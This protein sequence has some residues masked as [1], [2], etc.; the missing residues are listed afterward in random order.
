M[1]KGTRT[2]WA[3][4][5]VTA[6]ALLLLAPSAMAREFKVKI[7]NLTDGQPLTPPVIATHRGRHQVFDVG[8]PASVGVREIAENGNSAPLLAQLEAD[9]FNRVKDF[10]ESSAGPLAP[11][12]TPGSA[13]FDDRVKLR[14]QGRAHDRLSWVSMLICTNDGFTGVDGL[15]LPKHVGD[16]TRAR[17]NG[18][19][20]HTELNTEDY[21]DIVPPCQGLIGDT[22]GEPGTGVSDPAIA[23]GGVIAHHEG[24]DGTLDDLDSGIHGWTDPVAKIKVKRIG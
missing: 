10:K 9:P 20:S 19:D 4:L 17:T 15:R 5:G 3:S 11:E 24:I 21:A 12:G 7:V 8:Q 6:L 14:I 18:Y 23:E 22:S 2:L 1:R 13:M 16:R